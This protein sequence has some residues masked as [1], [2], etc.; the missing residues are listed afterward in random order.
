MLPTAETELTPTRERVSPAVPGDS[1]AP[2]TPLRAPTRQGLRGAALVLAGALAFFA[3][4]LLAYE[5][6]VARVPQHRAALERIV[7]AQ[8]GLDVRFN[9]LGLRWGWYG[10]EP[11]F[12][13]VELGDPNFIAMWNEMGGMERFDRRRRWWVQR[14]DGFE[15]A[16]C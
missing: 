16:L 14:R 2:V 3:I 10:P 9:E 4:V 11:V 5:L 1:V 13:R 7:R 12:R 15:K 8:T 6:A